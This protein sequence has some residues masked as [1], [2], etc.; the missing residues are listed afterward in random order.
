MTV[1]AVDV[2][3]EISD[4]IIEDIANPASIFKGILRAPL[5]TNT[6]EVIAASGQK[7]RVGVAMIVEGENVQGGSGEVR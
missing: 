6:F 2:A 5:G 7:F 1:D 3:L 4:L